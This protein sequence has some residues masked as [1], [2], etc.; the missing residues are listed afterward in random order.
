MKY[1][2]SGLSYFAIYSPNFAIQNSTIF[3]LKQSDTQTD[4][5]G[6]R[7]NN[8]KRINAKALINIP[9][10][11]EHRAKRSFSK[12][13]VRIIPALGKRKHCFGNVFTVLSLLE[14]WPWGSNSDPS[15]YWRMNLSLIYCFTFLLSFLKTF[16]PLGVTMQ[17]FA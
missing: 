4:T 2:I 9:Q 1:D 8:A 6:R 11:H 14:R 15:Q 10:E 12:E 7:C 13:R 16:M 3:E 17:C 5:E